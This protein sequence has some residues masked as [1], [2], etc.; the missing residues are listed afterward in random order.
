MDDVA[1]R[2]L[3]EMMDAGWT[4]TLVREPDITGFRYKIEASRKGYLTGYLRGW[5]SNAYHPAA[6]GGLSFALS[7]LESA[8]RQKWPPSREEEPPNDA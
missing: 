7:D 1:E 2:A 8:L 5:L 3:L 4:V 6:A